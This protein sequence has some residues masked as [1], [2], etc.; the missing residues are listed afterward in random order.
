[1]S[2]SSSLASSSSKRQRRAAVSLLISRVIFCLRRASC[3]ALERGIA[4]LVCAEKILTCC[5][6]TKTVV[7]R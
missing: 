4:V 5:C 7:S 3:R 2:I 1:M 6:H